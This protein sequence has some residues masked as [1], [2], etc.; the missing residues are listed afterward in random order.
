M[1]GWRVNV[2]SFAL[3]LVVALLAPTGR[4]SESLNIAC[5][6]NT[7]IEWAVGLVVEGLTSLNAEG[8]PRPSLATSWH[9]NADGLEWTF[10]LRPGVSFHD[11]SHLDAKDVLYSLG[12]DFH[13]EAPND[14]TIRI[15]LNHPVPEFPVLVS[16]VPILPQG[17]FSKEGVQENFPGFSV[18][19][20]IGTGPYQLNRWDPDQYLLLNLFHG[21]WGDIP[22]FGSVVFWPVCEIDLL[23]LML[24]KGT[25]DI[26]GGFQIPLAVPFV[27][28]IVKPFEEP[29][30]HTLLL[31]MRAGPLADVHVREA[32]KYAIDWEAVNAAVFGGMAH[33]CDG[34]IDSC[35]LSFCPMLQFLDNERAFEL[36][37]EAGFKRVGGK[38]TK[39]SA[40]LTLDILCREN[41]PVDEGIGTMTAGSLGE[42]GIDV[43]L[44]VAP[45]S[46]YWQLLRGGDFQAA[47]YD[48]WL[49]DFMPYVDRWKTGASDNYVGFTDED[50][51]ELIRRLHEGVS[52]N[53]QQTTEILDEISERILASSPAVWFMR[54]SSG[55]IM[56]W[57]S[58]LKVEVTRWQ[59]HISEHDRWLRLPQRRTYGWC[60]LKTLEAEAFTARCVSTVIASC[61]AC[62]EVCAGTLGLACLSCISAAGYH[63]Y[64]VC[65]DAY[66][67]W[68]YM[69]RECREWQHL[70]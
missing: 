53:S 5:P 43:R 17:F 4:A 20:L 32:L 46:A 13:A 35:W 56:A 28:L 68:S 33:W 42:F 44:V 8:Q 57:K 21:Y 2:V 48:M 61:P 63:T 59:V 69:I 29:S 24:E 58:D 31:N 54:P 22:P 7:E 19:T 64:S 70:W 16:R 11:G 47:V 10:E 65:K 37:S 25:A 34:P 36:M 67:Q 49:G 38:W 41:R 52:I 9:V 23:P 60:V 6:T 30:C 27:N 40:P 3:V 18:T 14:L 51:D 1:R 12:G 45:D 62:A 55:V 50:V 66:D 26:A 39:E 15:L